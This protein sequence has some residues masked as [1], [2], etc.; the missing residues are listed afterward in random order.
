MHINSVLHTAQQK[1]VVDHM[2]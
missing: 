1:H 2:Y